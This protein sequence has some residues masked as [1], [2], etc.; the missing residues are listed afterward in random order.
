MSLSEAEQLPGA[1]GAGRRRLFSGRPYAAGKGS[2]F[3]KLSQKIAPEKVSLQDLPAAPAV[4]M[5]GI[6]VNGNA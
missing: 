3:G 2:F 1:G 6:S 4:L 5:S